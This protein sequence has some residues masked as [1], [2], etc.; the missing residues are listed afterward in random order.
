M[1]MLMFWAYLF[2]KEQLVRVIVRIWEV[3]VLVGIWRVVSLNMAHRQIMV[4][5]EV[6]IVLYWG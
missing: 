4:Q 1:L 6:E 2:I 5:E 3:V